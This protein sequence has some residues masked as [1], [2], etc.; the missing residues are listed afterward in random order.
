MAGK[1]FP[2]HA[3]PA[4]LRIQRA[5][6]LSVATIY[7]PAKS[8]GQ[9]HEQNMH[10]GKN[11]MECMV[12]LSSDYL[13]KYHTISDVSYCCIFF[14]TIDTNAPKSFNDGHRK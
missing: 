14:N 1:T 3:Q 2:V 10:C 12:V 8:V 4:I 7:Y 11:K 9:M 13:M 5:F 6:K